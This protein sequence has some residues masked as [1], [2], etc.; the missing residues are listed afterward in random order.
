MFFFML[1]KTSSIIAANTMS[2][3]VDVTTSLGTTNSEKHVK[4]KLIISSWVDPLYET[5]PKIIFDKKT[6]PS[7]KEISS[8]Y[9]DFCSKKFTPKHLKVGRDLLEEEVE[10]LFGPSMN[11]NGYQ[12]CHTNDEE[13]I[14]IIEY[15]FMV[16]HQQTQV[17]NTHVINKAEARGIICKREGNTNTKVRCSSLALISMGP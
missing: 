10:A 11:K 5:P 8:K 9:V 7:K 1:V 3:S 14:A 4:L 2:L 12:Y 17:P 15:L 6:L 13:L 16:I